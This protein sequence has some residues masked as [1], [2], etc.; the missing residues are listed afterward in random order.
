[1][2]TLFRVVSQTAP[3]T[4][5]TKNGESQK[6]IIV[7]QELGNK[8]E[9]SFVASLIGN[10]VQL[11]PGDLVWASLRF[12]ASEFNGSTYQDVTIQ[13]IVSFTQH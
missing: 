7:L 6:S 13:E 9:D 1:M 12:S 2:K 4:I 5:N 3:M 10:Q 11:Y 8:Y